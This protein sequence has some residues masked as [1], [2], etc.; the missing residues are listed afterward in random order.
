M[1]LG[2]VIGVAAVA[3]LQ[4][5]FGLWFLTFPLVVAALAVP[6]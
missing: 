6:P 1:V 2:F 3:V 4:I 5:H